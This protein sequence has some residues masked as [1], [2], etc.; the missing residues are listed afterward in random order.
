M[1]LLTMCMFVAAGSSDATGT[2]YFPNDTS[3]YAPGTQ[4]SRVTGDVILWNNAQGP[5]SVPAV[6]YIESLEEEL[7]LLRQQ[8]QQQK[9]AVQQVGRTNRQQSK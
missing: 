3:A 1:V 4:K 6:D 5:Q 8:V 2:S 7:R 9:T